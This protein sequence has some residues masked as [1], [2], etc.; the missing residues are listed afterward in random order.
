MAGQ[1]EEG[2]REIA[3]ADWPDESE[4]GARLWMLRGQLQDALGFP[5]Q[6]LASY[7]EG[8]SVTARLLGQLAALRQRRGLLFQHRREL[9]IQLAGDPS[10]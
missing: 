4:A 1:H 7:G 3:Q 5:D 8:L 2:L 6:A 9:K 10:R